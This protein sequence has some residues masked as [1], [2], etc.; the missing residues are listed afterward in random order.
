M[1][2]IAQR[3]IRAI[4]KLQKKRVI[5]LD[6]FREGKARARDMHESLSQEA[7]LNGL[8]SAHAMLAHAQNLLSGQAEIITGLPEM[9]RFADAIEKATETYGPQ[10]PPM[11]PLTNSHFSTW[12]YYDLA[13][14]VRKETLATC[15][16]AIGRALGL[17][18]ELLAMWESLQRSRL[19]LYRHLDS[20]GD[21]VTLRELV[22]DRVT[23]CLVPSGYGGRKHE[24]WLG[25]L[26][27]SPDPSFAGTVMFITPYVVLAPP[28]SEWLAFFDRTLNEGPGG[29]VAAYERL[30]KY[31]LNRH[32]W[33]EYI[34][35]AYVNHRPGVIFLTGLPDVEESRPH[36]R[37]GL[38]SR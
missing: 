2:P 6:A 27:D 4:K 34:F 9:S 22:T 15:L 10:G 14:G 29:R 12:A 36:S 19:G 26:V 17:N 30:M 5:D 32:Y 23:Q 28:E 33:N 18:P 11:S 31:G 25:R 3:L 20:D 8:H 24:I 16:L 13:I 35:E 1:G 21:I 7:D 37:T 38:A